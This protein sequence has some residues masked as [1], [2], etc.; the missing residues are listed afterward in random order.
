MKKGA[1]FEPPDPVRNL[2]YYSARLH[3]FDDVLRKNPQIARE[4]LLSELVDYFNPYARRLIDR[5]S[6]HRKAK[7]PEIPLIIGVTAVQGARKTTDGEIMERVLK[8]LGY[9][10][11]SVSIDD[12][13]V[14]HD[15]LCQIRKKDKRFIR[16]GVT[17]D[18]TLANR[19]LTVLKT[20]KKKDVVL[21][22]AYHKKAHKGDGDRFA[23]ITL[24]PQTRLEG[25]VV[26][27]KMRVNQEMITV[28]AFT[29]NYAQ[30]K[31]TPLRL[32]ENMGSDIPLE[33]PFLPGKLASFLK[34]AGA[35]NETISVEHE[36]RSGK[37][38]A[39]FTAKSSI[40][41][42]P[43]S[44]LPVGWRIVDEKPDFIFYEGWMV[45]LKPVE[46]ERVFDK[47]L[48]AL[49]TKKARDFAR[50]VNRKLKEYLP[51]WEQ[52]DY[53]HIIHVPNY[54][55]S[56]EWRKQ[57]EI[58]FK[59]KGMSPEQIEEFVYYFWRSLHPKRLERMVQD[60]DTDQVTILRDDRSIVEVIIR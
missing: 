60:P 52:L 26:T 6:D 57:Q 15:E 56:I 4:S 32:P 51:L 22:A 2:Q 28:P 54:Q 58:A 49:K 14:T 41:S 20:M 46:D 5:L 38:H 37:S 18:L 1:E 29:I 27:Q 39:R 8:D 43:L 40:T 12:H 47:K 55:I 21:I 19:D 35:K 3:L 9:H 33:E 16:R 7:G 10:A 53:R 44:Q 30:Y 50:D 23:W 42:V 34:K 17:H 24:R 48:P 25:H 11:V 31:D 36:E 45:G 59:G 13:Y